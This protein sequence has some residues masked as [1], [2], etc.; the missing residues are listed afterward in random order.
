MPLFHL[1][2]LMINVLVTSIIGS[3]VICAPRFD[4]T[5]FFK[6]RPAPT[7]YSAVPTIHGEVLHYA[8]TYKPKHNLKLVR[9]C[10][11]A[12]PPHIAKRLKNALMDS[13]TRNTKIG[14]CT[15]R[16][17]NI[18]ETIANTYS[19]DYIQNNVLNF[20]P[21]G[22]EGE[23]VVR[24]K[25]LFKG[26]EQRDHLGYNPNV[27][28]KGWFDKYGHLHLSGR[29]KEVINRAGEK[30]SPIAVEHVCR[31]FFLYVILYLTEF[32]FFFNFNFFFFF[33]FF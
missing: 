5:L 11:A 25:C 1:H 10:S 9:N 28:D 19:K 23:V 16:N 13:K 21:T 27:W 29:F 26:Y 15:T 14:D 33:F 12:L 2:G 7:W 8:E 4:A 30:I 32:F 18:G 22:E 17:T 20:L 6:C 31:I 24:G 3:S